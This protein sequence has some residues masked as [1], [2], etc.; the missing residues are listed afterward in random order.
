MEMLKISDFL[1]DKYVMQDGKM[2]KLNNI[3]GKELT[4]KAIKK[5]DITSIEGL[6][7]MQEVEFLYKLIPIMTN[8]EMDITLEDFIEKCE[9]AQKVEFLSLV[10]TVFEKFENLYK[11]V[12]T[13]SKMQERMNRLKENN[14]LEVKQVEEKSKEQIEGELMEMIKQEDDPT[15]MLELMDKLKQLQD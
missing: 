9:L 5:E 15:K 13:M 10:D 8:I 2:K 3:E 11:S 6:D 1:E 4:F 7:N 14:V 12:Q